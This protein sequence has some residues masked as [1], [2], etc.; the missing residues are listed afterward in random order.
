MRG[1][2]EAEELSECG[3]RWG[4]GGGSWPAKDETGDCV[5]GSPV[6][7]VGFKGVGRGGMRGGGPLPSLSLGVR[8]RL[9]VLDEVVPKLPKDC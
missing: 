8:L 6:T 1:G 5:S 9:K 4:R 3:R 2:G 7:G